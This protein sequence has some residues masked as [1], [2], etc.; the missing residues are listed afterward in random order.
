MVRPQK[1]RQSG[2]LSIPML[3][4][5]AC[6]PV[7]HFLLR[8]IFRV[9]VPLVDFPLELVLFAGDDIEVIIGQ[10]SP[11]GVLDASMAPPKAKVT[12]SDRVGRA[13]KSMT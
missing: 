6:V 9:T 7:V 5:L 10:F 2:A 13:I 11:W 4:S 3:P 12:R 8:A 1:R